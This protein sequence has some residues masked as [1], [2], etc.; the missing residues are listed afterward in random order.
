M[1]CGL[2]FVYQRAP[3]S[4]PGGAPDEACWME[5]PQLLASPASPNH[6]PKTSSGLAEASFQ[7]IAGSSALSHN[8]PHGDHSD[9]RNKD[10]R[11]ASHP[12]TTSSIRITPGRGGAPCHTAPHHITRCIT[13]IYHHH[14]TAG[15][16]PGGGCGAQEKQRASGPR[17]RI[18]QDS[19]RSRKGPFRRDIS[20]H[21]PDMPPAPNK[22]ALQRGAAGLASGAMRKF[23]GPKG[24][25][26]VKPAPTGSTFGGCADL[27][28][29]HP[30]GQAAPHPAKA[31]RGR[32]GGRR[33]GPV[34][35]RLPG[36]IHDGRWCGLGRG[37]NP[38]PSVA[39]DSG[40]IREFEPHDREGA[41]V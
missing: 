23:E 5:R 8:L 16:V 27:G 26:R 24:S 12:I 9:T 32:G 35:T 14:F 31:D 20:C 22:K 13:I 29:P 36:G 38:T 6:R 39:A 25:G 41:G 7:F 15:L 1:R 34:G 17:T 30:R 19:S 10:G 37:R 11:R 40:D 4:Y 2:G 18:R 3:G 28:Q 21:K 33:L